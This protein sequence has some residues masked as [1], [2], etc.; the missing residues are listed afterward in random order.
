MRL[1]GAAWK[2]TQQQQQQQQQAA[3]AQVCLCGAASCLTA[4]CGRLFKARPG[5]QL[6][7][8]PTASQQP[9]VLRTRPAGGKGAATAS[10]QVRPRSKTELVKRDARGQSCSVVA[11]AAAG[12]GAAAT[13]TVV[14]M[15]LQVRCLVGTVVCN[16]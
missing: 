4:L 8:S 14:A 13:L 11:A 3:D 2:Q 9:V 7:Q 1:L 16:V 12:A 5:E 6:A 10:V 15:P